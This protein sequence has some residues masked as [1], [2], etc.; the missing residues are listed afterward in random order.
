MRRALA[1]HDDGDL[2]KFGERRLIIQGASHRAT[3]PPEA[4]ENLDLAEN[5]EFSVWLEKAEN[6]I[7]LDFGAECRDVEA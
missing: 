5:R 6:R 4:V 3:I 1:A 2:V 7:V